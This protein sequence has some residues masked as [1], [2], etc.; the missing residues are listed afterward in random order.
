MGPIIDAVALREFANLVGQKILQELLETIQ[1]VSVVITIG[2][3][4]L[5]GKGANARDDFVVAAI[6]VPGA[7]L[8][9]IVCFD[10]CPRLEHERAHGA[11]NGL[12][13][14]VHL[15]E[16]GIFDGAGGFGLQAIRICLLG[17]SKK[18][19]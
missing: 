7:V 10:I 11:P 17:G 8:T 9:V 19:L 6:D 5:D 12:V 2:R 15:V 13:V 14:G 1:T 16:V 4:R 3:P 18:V